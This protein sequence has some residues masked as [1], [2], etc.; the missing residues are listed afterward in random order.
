[1]RQTSNTA[2]AGCSTIEGVLE[3]IV[4]FNEE[5]NFTVARLQV[6]KSRDLVIIVG[7]MPCPNPG[8]TLR[9]KGQWVID[10]KFG[11][12]FRVESCLS[13]PLSTI[14]GIEKYLGSGLVKGIGP[15][16]A[17]R[18]VARFGLETLDVIEEDPQR[19]LEVDGIDPVRA[20]R[21]SKAW[22][23]QKEV[24]EVMVFLQS[25]GQA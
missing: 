11:R 20:E 6:G 8:E 12:Q 18:V 5:N 21:I 4:Y 16:M 7:S 1:M 2:A 23:E 22:Q 19:L 24:R 3:R 9:L 14:T 13:V 15:I 10:P 17:R 25:A